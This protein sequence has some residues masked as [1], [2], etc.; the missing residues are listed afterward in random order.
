MPPAKETDRNKVSNP[1]TVAVHGSGYRGARFDTETAVTWKFN[2]RRPPKC[3]LASCA[4][5]PAGGVVH[6]PSRGRGLERG[7]PH[8]FPR[9]ARAV[10]CGRLLRFLFWGRCPIGPG[11]SCF[12]PSP[13]GAGS[14]PLRASIPI[15]GAPPA[16]RRFVGRLAARSPQGRVGEVGNRPLAAEVRPVGAGHRPLP[17]SPAFARSGGSSSQMSSPGNTMPLTRLPSPSTARNTLAEPEGDAR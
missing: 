1:I 17:T 15:A 12:A 6:R 8:R 16:P 5:C 13:G 10:T 3:P 14:R 9:S 2:F 4:F 7:C 11:L